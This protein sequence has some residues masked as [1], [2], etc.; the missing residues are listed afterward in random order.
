MSEAQRQQQKAAENA[1]T[2][3]ANPTMRGNTNTVRRHRVTL[4]CGHP[5]HHRV[6]ASALAYTA[7]PLRYTL[8]E[9]EHLEGFPVAEEGMA[10]N[11]SES[12]L[13]KVT[14]GKD[15]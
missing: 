4:F 5:M 14:V 12:E 10:D 15:T 1:S 11:A 6:A 7:L 8:A 2:G 9:D 13:S 3:Q